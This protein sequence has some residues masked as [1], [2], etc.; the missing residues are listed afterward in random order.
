MAGAVHSESNCE[1][2]AD[3]ID[4]ITCYRAR[5][6]VMMLGSG[7]G[8][9]SVVCLTLLTVVSFFCSL[10]N[11]WEMSASSPKQWWPWALIQGWSWITR[12]SREFSYC[13]DLCYLVEV[14][15]KCVRHV[16]SA[17]ECILA[18]QA[19]ANG[20]VVSGAI[21]VWTVWLYII[22]IFRS[23]GGAICSGNCHHCPCV[24][25]CRR[26]YIQ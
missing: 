8:Y 19:A 23:I 2:K 24:R 14:Q 12:R 22:F 6:V 1:R 21:D 15:N 16:V 17:G 9:I 3:P 18:A 4:Y 13:W 26:I 5:Y 20:S 10:H 25:G 7:K 11:S